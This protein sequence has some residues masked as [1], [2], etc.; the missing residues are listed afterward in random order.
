MRLADVAILTQFPAHAD[1]SIGGGWSGTFD[2]A[3]ILQAMLSLVLA[4][5]LAA[6]IAYHPSSRGTVD[7][8]EED[9][10]QKA[11]LLYAVIG[12]IT[13]MMVRRY[14]TSVGF[15]VFGIGGLARFKTELRSGLMTGRLILVTLVGLSCGLALMQLA[16]LGTAFTFVLIA[17]LDRTTTCRVVVRG[18][19]GTAV[20][21]AAPAYRGLFEREGCRVLGERKNVAKDQLTLVIRMPRRVSRERL[22]QL[23]ETGIPPELRGALDW[24][25][26]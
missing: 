11:Y 9:E 25:T 12:A 22:E 23:I 6:A 15:V 24:E 8:L 21:S 14:G 18:L 13:G 3:F 20:V 1:S 16:V 2:S 17:A 19:K 7:T 26:E 10:A 4:T 5:V